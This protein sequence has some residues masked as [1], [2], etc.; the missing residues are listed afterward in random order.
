MKMGKQGDLL[1]GGLERL[2]PGVLGYTAE[3]GPALLVP[4]VI[5]EKEGSGDVGRYLDSLPRDRPVIF[6]NVI[7]ERLAGMLERRGFRRGFLKAPDVEAVDAYIREPQEVE[8]EK[9]GAVAED[10]AESPRKKS[11]ARRGATPDGPT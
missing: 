8:Q 5:A 1:R 10:S 7:N 2:A 9:P 11:P 3:V 4:L 6:P